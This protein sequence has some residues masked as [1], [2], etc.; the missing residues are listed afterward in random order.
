MNNDLNSSSINKNNLP[1]ELRQSNQPEFSEKDHFKNMQQHIKLN[2]MLLND[3]SS[4]NMKEED[5]DLPIG[6]NFNNFK[7]N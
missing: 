2:P 5:N 3:E 1:I 4:E 6:S 7:Q